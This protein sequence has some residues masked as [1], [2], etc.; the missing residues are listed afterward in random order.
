MTGAAVEVGHEDPVEIDALF[1]ASRI[2][3]VIT[4]NGVNRVRVPVQLAQEEHDVAWELQERGPGPCAANRG[5][6]LFG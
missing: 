6:A 4:V 3:I 1:P 5:G 2:N